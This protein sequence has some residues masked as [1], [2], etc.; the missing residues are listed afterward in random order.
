M[1][2]PGVPN[3]YDGSALVA[4]PVAASLDPELDAGFGGAP[5]AGGPAWQR[6]VVAISARVRALLATLHPA[7]VRVR[8]FWDHA[9]RHVHL[10]AGRTLEV[11]ASGSYRVR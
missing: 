8:N 5:N 11:D 10:G 2:D 1:N 6:D 3:L 9:V 4:A 7:I